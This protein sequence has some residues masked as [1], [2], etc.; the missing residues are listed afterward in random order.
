MKRTLEALVVALAISAPG[1]ATSS[2]LSPSYP[3]N[4]QAADG[5]YDSVDDYV[6]DQE[7]Q[8][9][10]DASYMILNQSTYKTQEGKEIILQKFGTS[11]IYRD[12]DTSTYLVTAN[13]VMQNEEV[14]HDFFGREYKKISEKCYIL[15]DN[16]VAQFQKILRKSSEVK[17][18]G[19]LYLKDS[20]GIKR[21][22]QNTVQVSSGMDLVFEAIK[23]KEVRTA[24]YNQAK[25]LAIV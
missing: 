21:K 12:V 18:A 4:Q 2:N 23:A 20:S 1:C 9:L 10:K 15:D 8:G 13:H 6:N 7:I 22:L 5:K 19:K 24:A 25:D 11:I 16:Q 14:L 3:L 17:D